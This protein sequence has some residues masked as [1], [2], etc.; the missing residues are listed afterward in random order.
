[1]TRQAGEFGRFGFIQ[2]RY[3][4]VMQAV[5][6]PGDFIPGRIYFRSEARWWLWLRRWPAG[7]MT[8]RNLAGWD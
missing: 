6:A 3:R 1:M 7:S 4:T 2:I 5:G 8:F